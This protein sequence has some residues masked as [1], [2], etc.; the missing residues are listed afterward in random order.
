MDSGS[1][2]SRGESILPRFHLDARE[3][4]QIA[5]EARRPSESVLI[6]TERDIQMR[7]VW[8][9]CDPQPRASRRKVLPLFI[10]D[11]TWSQLTLPA[12]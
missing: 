4:L 9:M 11:I 3:L 6:V 1:S 8:D 5:V 2:K 10:S 7:S 12:A